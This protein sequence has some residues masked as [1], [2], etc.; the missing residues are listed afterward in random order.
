[1]TFIRCKWEFVPS[2]VSKNKG[3]YYLVLLDKKKQNSVRFDSC[4]FAIDQYRMLY[5][6]DTDVEFI[7]CNYIS[8]YGSLVDAQ[9]DQPNR[10]RVSTMKNAKNLPVA[11]HFVEQNNIKR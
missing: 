10:V 4:V 5:C 1:M 2:K 3:S 8:S 6:N 11:R 7:D 9:A